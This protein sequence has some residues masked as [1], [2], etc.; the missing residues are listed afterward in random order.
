MKKNIRPLKNNLSIIFCLVFIFTAIITMHSQTVKY[1]SVNKQKYVMVDVQKTYERIVNK[2]YESPEIYEY[3]GNY[4][5]DNNNPRK[6]K[7]YFDKLF[8]NYTQFPF[9]KKSIERYKTMNIQIGSAGGEFS[10]IKKEKPFH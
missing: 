3:L 10:T 9:S 5:Y 2:G 1:D 7:L 4:Y 8:N 6:S